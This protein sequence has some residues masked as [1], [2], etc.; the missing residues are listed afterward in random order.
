MNSAWNVYILAIIAENPDDVASETIH[1]WADIQIGVETW[2]FI[3]FIQVDIK[4]WM[5]EA[6]HPYC[7]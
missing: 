5:N 1:K 4:M 7:Q 6:L 2:C 3:W